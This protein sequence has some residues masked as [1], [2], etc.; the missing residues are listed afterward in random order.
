MMVTED[1]NLLMKE[2]I[3]YKISVDGGN[4]DMKSAQQSR[5]QVLT[6][7]R[8]LGTKN[9]SSLFERTDIREKFPLRHVKQQKYAPL[10]I[11]RYLLSL[12]NFY[13]FVMSEDVVIEGVAPKEILRMKVITIDF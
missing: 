4:V 11:E 9:I 8:A 7:L 3:S 1:M 2:F 6:M 12:I 10:T 5:Q 13:D